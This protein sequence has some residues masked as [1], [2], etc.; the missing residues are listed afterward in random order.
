MSL[1]G[2]VG[3]GW[4]LRLRGERRAK[5]GDHLGP[6]CCLSSAYPAGRTAPRLWRGQAA[7][8][9]GCLTISA[10]ARSQEL[11]EIAAIAQAFGFGDDIADGCPQRTAIDAPFLGDRFRPVEQ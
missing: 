5:V 8:D 2:P 1:A 11:H 4:L 3:V 6:P 9:S 10:E 7:K